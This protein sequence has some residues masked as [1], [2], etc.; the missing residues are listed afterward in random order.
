[1]KRILSVLLCLLFLLACNKEKEEKPQ[2]IIDEE[3]DV[4]FYDVIYEVSYNPVTEE[5]D[6]F[7]YIIFARDG[8]FYFSV[9][10]CE[11]LDVVGGT[12]SIEG[13]MIYVLPQGHVC[14]MEDIGQEC[15][16]SG[17]GFK[18]NS[19]AELIIQLG[20]GCIAEESVFTAKK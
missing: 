6:R 20:Y 16:E 13:D 18:I 7:S 9:N 8:T 19:R 1:M 4:I 10:R 11:M 14:D 5:A 15:S 3:K 17:Y 12:F 2:D